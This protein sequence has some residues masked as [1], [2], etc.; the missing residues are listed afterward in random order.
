[1]NSFLFGLL[2]QHHNAIAM[3]KTMYE[4]HVNLGKNKGRLLDRQITLEGE[5]SMLMTRLFDVAH[6]NCNKVP[7]LIKVPA[8]IVFLEDQETGQWQLVR[9]IRNLKTDRQKGIADKQKNF[10]AETGQ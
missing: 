4:R 5:F 3:L 8:N 2:Q 6:A 1:M 7:N 10:S 9:K